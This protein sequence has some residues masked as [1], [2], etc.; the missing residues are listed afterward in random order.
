MNSPR[1][2]RCVVAITTVPLILLSTAMRTAARES[3]GAIEPAAFAATSQLD[4]PGDPAE[5]ERF[6][7]ALMAEDLKQHDIPGAAV[8]V[9]KDG[10]LFLAKGF[11]YADLA[12]KIPVDAERTIF[13]T[14]SVG[15]LFTWT[16]VMQLA[17]Q[18]KLDLDA[19][20]NTYLDF[21]I[22][23][24]FPQ[25]I[26]L[27]HLMTHTPGFEERW[28][29]AFARR[30][31]DVLPAGRWL[32]THVPARVLPPGTVAAYSNYGAMLAGYIVARVSG[33][34]YERYIAEHIFRP[35][36]MARSSAQQPVPPDLR[37]HTA[38][39]YWTVDGAPQAAPRIPEDYLGQLAMVPA[40]GHVSSVTDMARFMITH[41]QDGFYGDAST[42]IR[43]L[44]AATARRMHGTL[45]TPDPHILGSAYGFFDFSD[46]GRHAIGH[47]GGTLGFTTLLLLVPDRNL[48]VYVVYNAEESGALTT[49]H[50]GFQRAFFD[51]YFPAPKV[52]AIRPPSD[53]AARAGR[54][55]GTYRSTR[56]AY[57]SLEKVAR[58]MSPPAVVADPGDGTLLLTVHGLSMRLVEAAPSRFRQVD[59]PFGVL[60]RED[61]A[62]HVMRMFA[63]VSPQEDY[64]RLRWYETRG[65]NVALLLGCLLMFLSMPLVL[66]V[67]AAR[68]RAVADDRP[69]ASGGARAA[70]RLI[71]AV[72]AVNLL[73]VAGVV[74][75]MTQ[76]G[77]PMFGVTP[78]DRAVLGLGVLSAGLTVGVVVVAAR[79]WL[80]REWS[81]AY[82]TYYTLAAAA[83]V[84][85]VWFLNEW[86]LLGWRF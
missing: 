55:T 66:W 51:H 48:G 10:Q 4:G 22:P 62:D 61:E 56:T 1:R 6:L 72:C 26:T 29:E 40:G 60:F 58:L 86:N 83:A 11:G 81:V 44:E 43:I 27:K 46:N 15:K 17:E 50:F 85:F 82:R 41:L 3:V 68:G 54:F 79:A 53:F 73:F 19:D 75:M 84:G 12:R 18:G 33:E 71:G 52:D 59:A 20:V 67:R 25:P 42:E 76:L 37:A 16:A 47:T 35:L 34:P 65:F 69:P 23:D 5:M 57:S 70:Q 24:T 49:Q 74:R 78:L 77:F 8:A 39:G 9:V 21:R 14:G 30:S 2:T 28:F 64:E 13:P 38:L 32:S 63:D 7:S 45:F 36:G 31:T 80:R